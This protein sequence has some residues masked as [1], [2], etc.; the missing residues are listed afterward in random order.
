MKRI[1][2]IIENYGLRINNNIINLGYQNGWGKGMY[3]VYDVLK[4][5]YIP[6]TKNSETVGRCET[7]Y[8]FRVTDGF[9]FYTVVSKVDSGD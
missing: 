8:T 2:E 1:K 9:D 4:G 7:E 6:G 3:E 5:F